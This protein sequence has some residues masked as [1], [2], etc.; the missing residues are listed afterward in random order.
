M[1]PIKNI[2]LLTLLALRLLHGAE[3]GRLSEM[4]LNWTEISGSFRADGQE[5]ALGTPHSK[6]KIRISSSLQERKIKQKAPSSDKAPA[7]DIAGLSLPHS[8]GAFYFSRPLFFTGA[9]LCTLHLL[10][11]F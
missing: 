2:F 5:P 8:K 4:A 6:K 11:P 9:P 1:N 3:I 7:L 10:Y